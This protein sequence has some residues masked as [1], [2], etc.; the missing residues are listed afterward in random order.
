[1]FI[2]DSL[3]QKWLFKDRKEIIALKEANRKRRQKHI[4]YKLSLRHD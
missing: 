4:S 3:L 1:M 2:L